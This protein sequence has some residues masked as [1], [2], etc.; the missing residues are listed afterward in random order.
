MIMKLRQNKQPVTQE[1]V[2]ELRGNSFT[3]GYSLVEV[4]V[5]ISVLLIALVGP[6]TI[7]QTGLKRAIV[8]KDQTMAIFLAQ[9]GIEAVVRLRENRALNSSSYTDLTQVWWGEGDSL[10]SLCPSSGSFTCGVSVSETG[11]VTLYRCSGDT[12][13]FN[14]TSGARVPYK[15]QNGVNGSEPL[16]RELKLDFTDNQF[17]KVTSTV[18]W[19]G[20]NSSSV[21]LESYIYNTYYA[22]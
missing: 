9:E 10:R 20:G 11:G 3:A 15:Q 5:A 4:L 12:C 19:E 8:S 21:V 14:Y 18:A 2:K 6:L 17:I 22:P 1:A 16:R 7:A 13:K